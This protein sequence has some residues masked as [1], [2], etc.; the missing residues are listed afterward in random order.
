[1]R[2]CC[3]FI[4]HKKESLFQRAQSIF[5]S[6]KRKSNRELNNCEIR[7]TFGK[8]REQLLAEAKSEILRHEYRAGL[9]ENN[10]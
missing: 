5:M 9:A 10:T 2:A 4:T 8:T 7:I 1:M 3:R 6:Q